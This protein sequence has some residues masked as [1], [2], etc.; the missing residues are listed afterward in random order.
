VQDAQVLLGR[1]LRLLHQ[2][3]VVGQA[4]A[5]GREQVSS[6]AVVGERSRL[7]DQPVDDVPVGDPVLAT[8]PQTRQFFDAPLGVPH[9]DPLGV[10]PGLD[11][12][13][14]EPAG[15]RVGVALDV[16]GAAAIH[17][18]LLPLARLQTPSRQ[19]SQQRHLLS[20]PLPPVGVALLEQVPQERLVGGPTVE[21]AAAPQQ[22]R[23]FQ[24]SLELVMTLL[25]VAVLVGLC[26]LDGLAVQAVV[27][28]QRLI[29]LGE[30]GPFCPRRHG[31]GEPVGAVQLRHAAEL[32]QGVL[33][34]LAEALVALGE[35]DCAGLPV[36]VGQHEVVDQMLQRR[37]GDGH[38]QV[39]AVREIAGTEPTGMMHLGE[40]HLLGRP[41]FGP[42]LLDSPLQG[43]YLSVAEAT[44]EPPLQVGEQGLGLQTW[45]KAKLFL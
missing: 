4:E 26:R 39:G 1:S 25:D 17:P 6:V 35:A 19:R 44:G 41:F 3:R 21:V 34:A 30:R 10:D 28:Q 33:Q 31:G 36:G 29:P 2:Q 8:T 12:F 7:A 42:P 38:P 32:P 45:V 40:E 9:L 22:Q 24:G 14:D 37:A 16:A 5:D 27:P 23:L 11:P 43:P 20:Q 18:H 13:A 15:H